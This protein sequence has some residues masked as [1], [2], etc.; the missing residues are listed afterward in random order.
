MAGHCRRR[1]IRCLLAPDDAQ[2][3]C[4]NC[5]RLKKE[6]NFFPVDQQPQM[7]RRP[8]TASKA[9]A[10]SG[11]AS[12][13][14]SSSPALIAGQAIEPVDH[15]DRYPP[16]PLST[17]EFS[18]SSSLMS[19]NPLSPARRGLLQVFSTVRRSIADIAIASINSRTHEYSN[20]HDRQHWD[21]PFFDHGPVSTGQSTPEDASQA[22]WKLGESPMTP[23]F[24]FQFSGPPS[25]TAHHSRESISSFTT[26]VPPREDHGWPMPT[27]SMSFGG[28]VEDVSGT[29]PNNYRHGFQM[30]LR[31]RASEMNPPSLATSSNSSN[32]SVPE[33]QAAPHSAPMSNQ[34]AHHFVSP[35][36]NPL[37]GHPHVGKAPDYSVWYSEPPILAQVQEEEVAPPYGG[38]TPILYSNSGPH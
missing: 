36:W 8:R 7:E 4:S 14:S 22:Y 29:Y 6:C 15:Y 1:K 23:V 11:E 17:Q 31:R 24:P 20:P 34:P 9:E 12:A 33:A 37:P 30:D 35:T 32:T 21:S 27:R 5:I 19:A 26:F 38:D 16:L 18:A 3:R 13:S 25:S 2:N 10:G 28:H